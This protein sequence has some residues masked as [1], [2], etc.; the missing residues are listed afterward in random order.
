[1]YGREIAISL[2]SPNVAALRAADSLYVFSESRMLIFE[3]E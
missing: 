3:A 1:M 2:S